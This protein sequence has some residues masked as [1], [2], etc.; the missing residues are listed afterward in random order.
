MHDS[1]VDPL[2]KLLEYGRS[3]ANRR[4]K[5]MADAVAAEQ[6]NQVRELLE[7]AAKKLTDAFDVELKVP[8]VAVSSTVDIT[9]DRPEARTSSGSYQTTKTVQKR[10]INTLWLWKEDVKVPTTAYYSSTKYVVSTPDV[11]RRMSSTF[12]R[13]LG[14]IR[15]GLGDYLTDQLD[16]RLTAYYDEVDQYLQRYHGALS[17]SQTAQY[18]N[19]EDRK[20]RLAELTM[21]EDQLA[22][23]SA[24]LASY[25]AQLS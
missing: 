2:S 1:V 25:R 6:Q 18:K 21:L 11:K 13:R 14:E 19:D 10:T 9:L 12:D 7:R 4:I 15:Q 20:H 8:D 3:E 17:R 22:A 23:E 5:T 24:A 16:A